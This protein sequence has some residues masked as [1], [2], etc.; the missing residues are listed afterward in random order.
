VKVKLVAA[1]QVWQSPDGKKTIW[2]VKDDTGAVHKTYDHSLA[3]AAERGATVEVYQK[4]KDGRGGKESFLSGPRPSAGAGGGAQGGGDADDRIRGIATSYA[5]NLVIA[6][7]TSKADLDMVKNVASEVEQYMRGGAAEAAAT[8][9]NRPY[10]AALKRSGLAAR[11]AEAGM[12]DAALALMWD[13]AGMEDAAF[14]EAV[15]QRVF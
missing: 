3:T 8:P 11:A 6:G 14:I 4:F 2:E 13:E 7:K 10:A 1:K 5:V 12:T 15:A 9:A